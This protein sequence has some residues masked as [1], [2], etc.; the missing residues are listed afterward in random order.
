MTMRSKT[1]QAQRV[2][3]IILAYF[4]DPWQGSV[5]EWCCYVD[6]NGT[7][8]LKF[9]E[10]GN[11]KPFTVDGRE[12]IIEP[13]ND[14]GDRTIADCVEVFGSQTGK[15]GMLMGG[16][17]W[18]IKNDC[19]GLLWVMP[20]IQLAQSFSETRWQ[21]MLESSGAFVGTIPGGADRHDFKKLQQQLCGSVVN[22]VGSN[23]PANLASRPARKVVLDEVD[24]FDVGGGAE[25][26]AVNLAEQR[27]KGQNYPQRRKTSTPTLVDGLIWQEFLKGDQRRFFVP[28]PHC[29]KFV[30]F[31][32]SA[33]FTVLPKLSECAFVR[34]DKE[35]KRA[36]GNWD[37][38]RVAKS[39]R[40]EC[41]HCGGHIL[42]GH[43]TKMLVGGKWQATAQNELGFRSRH[44]PSMYACRPETTF[45]ALAVKFLRSKRSLLGLQG[46][47]NG[48][49]AEPYESQD[50]QTERVELITSR[51]EVK[52]EWRKMLTV[53]CQAR[54]PHF[55]HVIRAWDGANSV[56]V[57]AGPLD[58]WD[59]IRSRQTGAGVQDVGV[60]IDSGYGAKSDAEVY[61]SCVRFCEIVA[62]RSKPVAIG[63]MPAKGMPT[64]KRWRDE[65]SGLMVPYYLRAID[66]FVGTAEA[67]RV[68]MSLFEFAGDFFKDILDMLRKGQGGFKWS[69]EAEVATDEY[70]RHMDAEV[71]MPVFSKATGRT[72]Y[73]WQPRSRHWPN[74]LFDC[75]VMQ[76]A[77]ANFFG[78][79]PVGD[80]TDK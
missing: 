66:P 67:G 20:S 68:E 75:E 14:W 40:S 56:G 31:A 76:V 25:A 47:I 2:D 6:E 26:D 45:G 13:L 64:R 55:W 32:W 16:A 34:W 41:P 59:D 63:W 30:V 8:N 50:R 57:G 23:S 69:V 21:P 77:T 18:S 58:T 29:S 80:E 11:R 54:A 9:N 73:Q 46:F 78:L 53:D 65:T 17:A 36:D 42:D 51:V 60:V 38:D 33:Q 39:A 22:F 52:A 72:T 4:Q 35:A 24:K 5:A 71:K 61:R 12:Y 7:P 79:F 19:C 49:L 48:D 10:P 1:K 43:K 70:W 62:G 15:T 44:L 27:T 37:L 3:S 28:C 74:H